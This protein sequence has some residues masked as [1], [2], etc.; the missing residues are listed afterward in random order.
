[1]ELCRGLPLK[2]KLLAGLFKECSTAKDVKLELAEIER[3]GRIS[4][5]LDK[6]FLHSYEALDAPL[7]T[8]FLN[9]ALFL[10]QLFQCDVGILQSNASRW[11]KLLDD[12]CPLNS[13]GRL[14]NRSMV[15]LQDCQNGTQVVTVHDALVE[16]AAEYIREQAR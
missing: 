9:V 11:N 16:F 7:R 5:G 10:P 6:V 2:V 12:D 13:L 3:K 14:S 4:A 8:A 15:T 1:M